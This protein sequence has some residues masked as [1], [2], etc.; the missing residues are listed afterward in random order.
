MVRT[1]GVCGLDYLGLLQLCIET[2]PLVGEL[3]PIRAR[4]SGAEFRRAARH[5]EPSRSVSA[6]PTLS[7]Y[8]ASARGKYPESVP[9]GCG[10]LARTICDPCRASLGP[11]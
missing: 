10:R 2:L 4:A 6:H 9:S 11:A 7:G 1:A 5:C 8:R 3:L